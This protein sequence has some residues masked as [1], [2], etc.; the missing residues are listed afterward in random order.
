[1]G[2]VQMA[3]R[4]K[5]RRLTDHAEQEK[6]ARDWITWLGLYNGYQGIGQELARHDPPEHS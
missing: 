6:V 3:E 1:M 4:V 2:K 5:T